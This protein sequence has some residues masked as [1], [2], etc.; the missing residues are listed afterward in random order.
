[1]RESSWGVETA[2]SEFIIIMSAGSKLYTCVCERIRRV[3]T[4]NM[5]NTDYLAPTNCRF[6]DCMAKGATTTSSGMELFGDHGGVGDGQRADVDGKEQAFAPRGVIIGVDEGQKRGRAAGCLGCIWH[7]NT[8]VQRLM[9][10]DTCMR[11]FEELME[12]ECE[13]M[14]NAIVAKSR[15]G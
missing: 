14:G 3:D 13:D 11:R 4:E 15:K 6:A 10:S 2:T 5:Y 1:M 7:Q 9:H 12:H 8:L